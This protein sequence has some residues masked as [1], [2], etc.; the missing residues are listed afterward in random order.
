MRAY[1]LTHGATLEQ[2]K[3]HGILNST[4]AIETWLSPFPYAAV[5]VSKLTLGELTAVIRSH[6]GDHWFIVVETNR[7]NVNGW[8]PK[9][10]WDYLIDPQTT[11]S[12]QLFAQYLKNLPPPP[13]PQGLLGK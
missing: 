3:V 9:Q 8:L 7:D 12:Q 4:R 1:L 5:L 2:E 10:F 11:W 6:F 13:P